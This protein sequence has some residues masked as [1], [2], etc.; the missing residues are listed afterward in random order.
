MGTVASALG[1]GKCSSKM[2]RSRKYSRVAGG[3][4]GH[5]AARPAHISSVTTCTA[6]LGQ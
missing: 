3:W 6:A 1:D 4:S 2:E 5:R